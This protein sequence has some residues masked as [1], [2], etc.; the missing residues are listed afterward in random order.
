MVQ[1]RA[2]LEGIDPPVWRRVLVSSR[3]TLAELHGVLQRCF[4]QGDT[5][6]HRFV[7]DGVRFEDPES[8]GDPAHWTGHNDLRSIALGA[9]ARLIHEVETGDQPW[10]QVLTVELRSPRLVGQRLPWCTEGAGASPPDD[11]DGP[12][13]YRALLAALNSPLDPRAVELREWLPDDF[14]PGFVDLT[15]INAELGRLPKQRL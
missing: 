15:T 9:G 5:M 12:V 13:R 10:R 11:C 8:G 14:D 2:E 3:A 7:I 4:G 6:P 1:L